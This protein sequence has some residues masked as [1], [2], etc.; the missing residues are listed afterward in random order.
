MLDDIPPQLW[1]IFLPENLD[2]LYKLE[3][4]IARLKKT[5]HER[6]QAMAIQRRH[7]FPVRPNAPL[8]EVMVKA[9]IHRLRQIKQYKKSDKFDRRGD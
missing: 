5:E 2:D 1:N 9:K 8:R 3:L 6:K 7:G 4:N